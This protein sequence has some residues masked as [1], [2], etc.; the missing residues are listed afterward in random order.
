[1]PHY[2]T[3]ATDSWST[4]PVTYPERKHPSEEAARAYAAELVGRREKVA[5]TVLED[6][7][8]IDHFQ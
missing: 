7:M 6:G 1:M 4:Q 5:V 8:P 2:T 3:I